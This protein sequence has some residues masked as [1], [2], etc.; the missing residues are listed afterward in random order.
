MLPSSDREEAPTRRRAE[1]ISAPGRAR[2]GTRSKGWLRAAIV[3]V[4]LATG[5]VAAGV[6]V[7]NRSRAV[8]APA[9]VEE[10]TGAPT[11]PAADVSAD[12][13]KTLRNAIATLDRRSTALAAAVLN[14]DRPSAAAAQPAPPPAAA[15]KAPMDQHRETLRSF[16]AALSADQGDVPDRRATE[17]TVR[18]ELADSAKGHARVVTVAC[19]TAFCKAVL[20]EDTGVASPLDMTSLVEA[21][22]FLKTEAMF[23]YEIDGPR[24]R[25]I[26]YAAR[27]GHALPMPRQPPVDPKD[28]AAS[29]IA[30]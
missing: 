15:P 23:D 12:E 13:L 5:A 30:H 11:G 7:R 10:M 19:A 16:D 18:K 8:Q 22:P 24:R 9:A 17:E 29:V 14:P 2:A 3:I 27:A 1:G 25:T 6:G 26:V 4:A 21:S 20:E 28:L